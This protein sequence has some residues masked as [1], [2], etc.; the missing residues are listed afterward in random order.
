MKLSEEQVLQSLMRWRSRV[1]AVAWMVVRD[2]HA[3]E[4]IFQNVALKAMTRGALFDSEAALMSWAVITARR[5]GIDWLRRHHRESFCLDEDILD[6]LERE[7]QTAG[8][9]CG[10]ERVEAL[11][12]CLETVPEASRRMLRL[13]YF[14]G[15][16]CQQ[17]AEEMGIGLD[18]VYKRISRLHEALRECIQAKLARRGISEGGAS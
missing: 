4:D 6:L 11:E 9:L 18:A 10:G 15:F 3:A 7:I 2:A 13:R 14:D 1:S 16:S 8:A 12:S 5:E 17:V